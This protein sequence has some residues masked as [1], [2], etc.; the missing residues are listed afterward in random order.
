LTPPVWWDL[1]IDKTEKELRSFS[2]DDMIM[3]W[4]VEPPVTDDE[5]PDWLKL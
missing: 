5:M 3:E 4:F 2:V 1:G